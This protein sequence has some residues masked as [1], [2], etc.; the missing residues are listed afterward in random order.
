LQ[1]ATSRRR[2]NKE[3]QEV[4]AMEGMHQLR[5]KIVCY[6]V[7]H[8][9]YTRGASL[10][11][12]SRIEKEVTASILRIGIKRGMESRIQRVWQGIAWEDN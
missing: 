1:E 4:E 8:C 9:R 3:K 11:V 12:P 6:G 5:E 7:H 10:F 2:A